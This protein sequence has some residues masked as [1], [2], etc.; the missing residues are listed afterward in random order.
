MELGTYHYDRWN[1]FFDTCHTYIQQHKEIDLT[2]YFKQTIQ[3]GYDWD[4][5]GV[6]YPNEP[7]GDTYLIAQELH[8]KY[9]T[10]NIA[11]YVCS[12]FLCFILCRRSLRTLLL[13]LVDTFRQ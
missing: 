8:D 1:A 7:V 10:K 2:E 4:A 3:M 6:E 13:K 5:D 12:F 11:H 9:L